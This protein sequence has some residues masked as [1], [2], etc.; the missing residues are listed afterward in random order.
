MYPGY[1]PNC[2]PFRPASAVKGSSADELPDH[3]VRR[4]VLFINYTE[5]LKGGK[6]RLQFF[7]A[8]NPSGTVWNK[9]VAVSFMT[10]SS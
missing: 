5:Q 9:F 3:G 8:L 6:D 2:I 1:A 10:A 4:D 7:V